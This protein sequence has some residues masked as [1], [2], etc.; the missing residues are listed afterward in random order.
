[1]DAEI[2]SYGDIRTGRRLA[3]LVFVLIVVK[4]LAVVAALATGILAAGTTLP[5]GALSFV[6]TE[7]LRAA[8]AFGFSIVL[9]VFSYDGHSWA[10]LCLGL[11]YIFISGEAAL[12]ALRLADAFQ[13]D[14]SKMVIGNAALG[15]I[16]G[17]M[18]VFAPP[19]RAFTWSQANRRQTIPLPLDDQ[20]VRRTMRRQRSLGEAIFAFFGAVANLVIV[21]VVLG[22]GAFLYGFGDEI[23]HWFRP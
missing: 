14:A 21:L 16:I 15:L 13:T 2:W 10:R 23:I 18:V 4:E 12:N 3:L 8:L 20:P 22:L 7:A 6:T 5:P 9:M 11:I 17:L 1:M 19:L